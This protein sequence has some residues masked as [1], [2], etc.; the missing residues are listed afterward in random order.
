MLFFHIPKL[1]QDSSDIFKT[2]TGKREEK[3]Q[4]EQEQA[5]KYI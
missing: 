3:L 5:L 4:L 2:M 1:R